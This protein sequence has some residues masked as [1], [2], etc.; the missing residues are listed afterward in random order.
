MKGKLV[1]IVEKEDEDVL[2][3]TPVILRDSGVK[4]KSQKDNK[5]GSKST[6]VEATL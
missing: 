4:K 6:I 2:L 1:T 5:T 3:A